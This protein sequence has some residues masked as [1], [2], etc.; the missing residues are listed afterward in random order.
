MGDT[1]VHQ[2]LGKLRFGGVMNRNHTSEIEGD[3]NDYFSI[4]SGGKKKISSGCDQLSERKKH[5]DSNSWKN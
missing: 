1:T 2:L 3:N 5:F 4:I